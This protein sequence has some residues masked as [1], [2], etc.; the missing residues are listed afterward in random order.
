MDS[1]WNIQ[2]RSKTRRFIMPPNGN[3]ENIHNPILNRISPHRKEET[4]RKRV[5]GRG[6]PLQKDNLSAGHFEP[7]D[8]YKRG[9]INLLKQEGKNPKENVSPNQL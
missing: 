5:R 4:L 3:M 6:M 7:G 9:I 1:E 8:L 2:G